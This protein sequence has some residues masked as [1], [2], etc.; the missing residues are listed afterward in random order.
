MSQVSIELQGKNVAADSQVDSISEE[1]EQRDY[2]ET[3]FQIKIR[4]NGSNNNIDEASM[5]IMDAT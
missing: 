2:H 5:K 1:K 4:T 3:H